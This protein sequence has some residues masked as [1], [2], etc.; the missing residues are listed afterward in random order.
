MI[1]SPGAPEL[2]P[3]S[4]FNSFIAPYVTKY[5]YNLNGEPAGG[6]T[7]G[8]NDLFDNDN[9]Y[10]RSGQAG[11][12]YT[13]GGAKVTHDLHAGYQRSIDAEN[14]RRIRAVEVRAL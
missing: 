9:F 2:A 13:L 6:G 3:S 4:A 1:E 14:L 10:R 8:A 12:N 5:G 7:V 11:Y